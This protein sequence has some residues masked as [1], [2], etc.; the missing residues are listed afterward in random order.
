MELLKLNINSTESFQITVSFWLFI[1]A[2]I[3]IAIAGFIRW[4]WSSLF[5]SSFEIDEAEIG[6]GSQKIK[7]KPSNEDLQIAYKLWV[8]LSTR[9]IGIKIDE[10][11]DV[12][13][14][15]YNSWY[16]FF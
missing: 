5:Y 6:I 2:I 3:A 11:H 9:K 16:E 14:E 12:I 13:I 7:I 1:S 4:K 10:E 8:E 15:V